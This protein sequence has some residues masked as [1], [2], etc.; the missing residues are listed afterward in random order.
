MTINQIITEQE[1]VDRSN[2]LEEVLAGGNYSD[3]CVQ[4]ANQ[5]ENQHGRYIWYF[6]KTNFEANPRAEMLNLLGN[7]NKITTTLQALNRKCVKVTMLKIWK[8]S[9]ESIGM[10]TTTVSTNLVI[11][12]H[13]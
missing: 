6:V 2:K 13:N 12:W 11:I 3:Y 1:L 9:M 5:M 8:Q 7:A 10:P 4:K